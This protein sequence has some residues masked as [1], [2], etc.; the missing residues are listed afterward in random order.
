MNASIMRYDMRRVNDMNKVKTVI[1]VLAVSLFFIAGCGLIDNGAGDETT[2]NQTTT[3]ESVSSETSEETSADYTE[4]ND[5]LKGLLPEETGFAWKYFGTAEYGHTMT[6]NEI[7]R[8]D[9]T[10]TYYI[11]GSVDDMSDGESGNDF[12]LDVRYVI[13]NGELTQ[14]AES[15]MMLDSVYKKIVLIRTPLEEGMT[16]TQTAVAKDGTEEELTCEI[17]EVK[18]DGYKTYT[19]RYEQADTGYYEVR[20][21]HENTGIYTF[22]RQFVSDGEEYEIGF[23]LYDGISGYPEEI[24]LKS[25]LPPYDTDLRY[26]GLAEYGHYVKWNSTV[27][28][29]PDKIIYGMEGYFNDGSG[30]PGSFRVNYILDRNEF[31]ITESVV[32]NTRSGLRM[33]NS[34]IPD[35]IILKAPLDPGNSWQQQVMINDSEYTMNALITGVEVDP[36]APYLLIYSVEYRVSGMTGYFNNEYIQRR[37]FK[38]GRGMISFAQLM[39]GDIG[40]SGKDLENSYLVEEAIVNHMFGYSQDQ[41][42]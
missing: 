27:Y 13:E 2:I 1:A 25:L 23:S 9:G 22:Y 41:S 18:D 40:I 3:D 24:A 34:I 12:S 6:V 30:I 8:E 33:I 32:E 36:N 21:I 15:D 17:T 35:M 14:Y 29:S 39:E 42:Q 20:E 26:F 37:S 5:L 38:T 11:S 31:T 10:T 28:E 19:V 16:W 4:E 7:V